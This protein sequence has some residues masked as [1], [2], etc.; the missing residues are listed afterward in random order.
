MPNS[1][2]LELMIYNGQSV[3]IYNPGA[4][5]LQDCFQTMIALFSDHKVVCQVYSSTNMSFYVS[6]EEILDAWDSLDKEE[7]YW[8]SQEK[9]DDCIERYCTKNEYGN[10]LA[11]SLPTI[12]CVETPSEIQKMIDHKK[13]GI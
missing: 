12:Y 8:V 9:V 13:E 10:Y 5:K 1:I 7:Y 2:E 11:M 6:K 4:G 3:R